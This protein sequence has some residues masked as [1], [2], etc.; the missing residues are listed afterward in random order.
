VLNPR[1]KPA[2]FVSFWFT[3]VGWG[4][5]TFMRLPKGGNV[6]LSVLE[7]K[8]PVG[9]FAVGVSSRDKTYLTVDGKVVKHESKQGP[10]MVECVLNQP[11]TLIAGNTLKLSV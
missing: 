2:R 6:E 7:G 1:W 11:V 4:A 10:Q 3:G 8:L 5:F 9:S